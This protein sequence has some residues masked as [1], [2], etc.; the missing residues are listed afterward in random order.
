[1]KRALELDPRL[2]TTRKALAELYLRQG[3]ADLAAETVRPL[4]NREPYDKSASLLFADAMRRQRRYA[5]ARGLL[6][7][8]IEVNLPDKDLQ[9]ALAR[10]FFSMGSAEEAIQTFQKVLELD[11]G[12]EEAV[13]R[14]AELY[15][16]QNGPGP[17]RTWIE[18][19]LAAMPNKAR[20]HNILG[21]IALLEKNLDQAERNF[22]TALDED[23]NLLETYLNL[24]QVYVIQRSQD[25]AL[26]LYEGLAEKKPDTPAP[27]MLIGM[28][29]ESMG[30]PGNAMKQY[31]KALEVNPDFGPAANNLAWLLVEQK[32]DL[33]NA[34]LLA[35]KAR[36]ALPE[37]PF[38][39]DTLGWVYAKKGFHQQ[40]VG[41]FEEA[42]TQLP[43]NPTL[44][45]HLGVSY[46]ALGEAEKARASLE[47]A[48]RLN[49]DFP[50][51]EDSTKLL[52]SLPTGK[53]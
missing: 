37:N 10:V 29:L 38:V 16:V 36:K 43:K 47:E 21:K 39:A 35:E 51:A 32:K 22:R 11:P 2:E 23:P 20:F 8:L 48:L 4:L 9:A 19:H 44:Q 14:I 28:L 1:L 26:K 25:K 34:L 41:L 49:P 27:Y 31:E 15:L 5:D 33:E 50:E 45:Y 53:Q 12:S 42:I 52:A 6:E 30:D 3:Q 18:Q 24:G 46:A 7:K 40:A 17:A 13:V